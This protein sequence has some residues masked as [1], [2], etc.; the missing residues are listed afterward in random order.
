MKRLAFGR[1]ENVPIRRG[2]LVLQPWPTTIRN[3]KFGAKGS[4]PTPTEFNLKQQVVELFEHVR[5]LDVGEIQKLEVRHGLPF[6]M[7]LRAPDQAGL[8]EERDCN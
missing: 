8:S 6:S 1:F 3:L 2:E 7:E 4:A 5:A